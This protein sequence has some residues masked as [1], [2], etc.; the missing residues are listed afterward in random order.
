VAFA[1]WCAEHVLRV[2]ER[3]FPGDHRPHEVNVLQRR[4]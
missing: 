4:S 1:C 2:F 3:E